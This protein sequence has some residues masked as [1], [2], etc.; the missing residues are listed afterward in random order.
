MSANDPE[1]VNDFGTGQRLRR[2]AVIRL[3]VAVTAMATPKLAGIGQI[4]DAQQRIPA[5][6]IPGLRT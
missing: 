6:G 2:Q 4:I 3:A 1:Q 5:Q